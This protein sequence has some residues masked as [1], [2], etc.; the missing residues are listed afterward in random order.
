MLVPAA[1]LVLVILGAIAVDLSISLLGQRE[2]TNAAAAAANDAATA[3]IDKS[4]FYRGRSGRAPGTVEVD[5]A[6]AHEV[7][8]Q[9]LTMQSPRAVKVTGFEV[10]TS[11]SQVCVTLEGRVEYLFAKA[12]P[13]VAH[14]ATVRGRA[15]ATAVEGP[16]GSAVRS[17]AACR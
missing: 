5:G 14:G 7:V 12:I 6:R 2:L 13:G 17:G 1:V 9:V 11:A 4:A 10:H 16:A 3:A 15:T 8:N